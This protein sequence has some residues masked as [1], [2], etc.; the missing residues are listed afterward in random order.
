MSTVVSV[1]VGLP[2]DVEWHGRMVQTAIW[3]YPIAGRVNVGRLNIAGDGQADTVGHGG[4]NRAVMVYQTQSYRYWEKYLKR[5]ALEIGQFGENLTVDGLA[6]DEVCIGDRFQIGDLI[7]EVTQPRV[8]CYK[9]GIRMQ[10]PEIAALLVSH[11]RPGFYC[12][13]IQ[14][15]SIAAGDHIQKIA[16]GAERMTV[17]DI[18]SLLYSA[19]HPV[20]LLQRAMKI[21]PL[22]M[23]WRESFRAL[24]ATDEEHHRV[25]NAALSPSAAIPAAWLG[26]RRLRVKSVS[27]ETANVKSFVLVSLDG[28]PLPDALPGQHLTIKVSLPS[29]AAPATRNYSLSGP[30]GTGAYRITIKRESTGGV[31]RFIHESLGVD[32]LVEV[33]APRGTFVLRADKR[34]VVLLSAGIGVTP[35][36]AMLYSIANA[37]SEDER[38]LWWFHGTRNGEHHAFSKEAQQIVDFLPDA[39]FSIFYSSPRDDDILGRDYDHRGRIDLAALKRDG[40]PQDAHFYLCGPEN[41]IAELSASLKDWGVNGALV[42]SEAFGAGNP[43]NLPGLEMTFRSPHLP[44][45]EPGTGPLVTMVKSGLTLR[46]DTRFASLLELA[47]ACDVPVKW[48]CRSGVC[49]N[50]ECSLIDGDIVYSPNP[51]DP[52][53]MGAALI[54]CATPLT[55]IQ[56]DL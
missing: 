45:G 10:Y 56:L 37:E 19:D 36:L 3:K 40:V 46:W 15:G 2:R 48:S 18:D 30:G 34:P 31:S 39:R 42:H 23:G 41:F 16:D 24:L 32:E 35:L 7:L 44:E 11:R 51:L 29:Q 14:E 47:E 38:K 52:P 6:D 17:A 25:G 28:T 12:R 21:S 27:S 20:D 49:H 8:T 13:V 33:S 1:N 4:E 5:P 50:C 54:C 26:F 53:L 43:S 22:S 55:D 9:L